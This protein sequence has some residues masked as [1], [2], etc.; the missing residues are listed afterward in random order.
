MT[1]VR[2]T[3]TTSP[4]FRQQKGSQTRWLP[5]LAALAP[6]LS[7]R[8][9]FLNRFSGL[10][11]ASSGFFANRFC[12]FRRLATNS[13]RGV[14]CF[15]ADRLCSLGGLFSDRLCTFCSFRSYIL[16]YFDALLRAFNCLVG[17]RFRALACF[18]GNESGA[19]GNGV[20]GFFQNT[21]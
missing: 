3:E 9:H 2:V 17:D 1:G 21:L 20:T 19:A 10:L 12:A 4:L 11:C 14:G 5:S 15:A 7:G 8:H 16:S 6:R 13:L 18:V